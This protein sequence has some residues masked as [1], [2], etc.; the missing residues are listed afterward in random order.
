MLT[1]DGSRWVIRALTG[2]FLAPDGAI[3]DGTPVVG[4]NQSY[5]WDIRPD[6]TDGSVFK[7][8]SLALPQYPVDAHQ[9]FAGFGAPTPSMSSIF[10]TMATPSPALP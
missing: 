3:N 5:A 8:P 2:Q 1:N 10:L 6:P 4:R 7:Y 9:S